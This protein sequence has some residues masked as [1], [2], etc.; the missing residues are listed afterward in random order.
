MSTKTGLFAKLFGKN[1]T[2]PASD[3]CDVQIIE[4][5]ETVDPQ[6]QPA[7]SCCTTES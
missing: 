1:D 5:D 2:A 6:Q 7:D 4:E 3:C